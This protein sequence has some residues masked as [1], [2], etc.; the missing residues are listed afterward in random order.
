MGRYLLTL[1]NTFPTFFEILIFRKKKNG[2]KITFFFTVSFVRKKRLFRDMVRC[3]LS[4]IT[5]LSGHSWDR[6]PYLGRERSVGGDWRL[7]SSRSMNVMKSY[8]IH[9]KTHGN[10]F[11]SRFQTCFSKTSQKV[12]QKFHKS[13]G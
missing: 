5:D 3:T 11:K 4:K 1:R 6:P 2:E 9:T 10:I 7:G 13:D 8:E 12:V